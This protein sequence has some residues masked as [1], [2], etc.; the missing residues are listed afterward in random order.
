MAELNSADKAK[1]AVHF[2]FWSGWIDEGPSLW[3]GGT[4]ATIF[5]TALD[6]LICLYVTS[7]HGR[8]RGLHT[9]DCWSAGIRYQI[10]SVLKTF[11]VVESLALNGGWHKSRAHFRSWHN[12][13]VVQLIWFFEPEAMNSFAADSERIPTPPTLF[14]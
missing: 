12:N 1:T 9:A 14:T 10:G 2:R 6:V 7:A 8:T 3:P 13:S 5:H 4:T 11:H